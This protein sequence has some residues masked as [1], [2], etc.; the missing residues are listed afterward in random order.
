MLSLSIVIPAYN[1]AHR[2]QSTLHNISEYFSGSRFDDT[3]V[4]LVDDGS[5]DHTGD[6]ATLQEET[7]R[8]F[9]VRLHVLRNPGNKGKGYSVRRGMREARHEWVLFTDADLS[10]PIQELDNLFPAVNGGDHDVAIGSRAVD[11][12]LIGVRQAWWRE[13]FGRL[14]NVYTRLV[15]G[16]NITDTQCGFK[17]FSRQA[18][19]RIS[20][21]QRIE[22][23]GFDVE[24]LFLAR[25][26]GF[27]VVEVPVRWN[28]APESSVTV[29]DGFAAFAEVLKVRWNDNV[30]K[31]D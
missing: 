25:K 23:F 20:A 10:T 22:G 19:A 7:L 21:V 24:Q 13:R 29:F 3:E 27:S 17:L 4:I 18:A 16:L 6:V 9:G 26:M 11:R 2:L 31:Y 14:F 12:S 8:S 15:T 5:C 28:D 30:G 1:E